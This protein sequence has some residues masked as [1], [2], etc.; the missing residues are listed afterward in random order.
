MLYYIGFSSKVNNDSV[1]YQGVY[2]SDE[3]DSK[4]HFNTGNFIIDWY[5]CMKHLNSLSTNGYLPRC[6]TSSQINHLNEYN[7]NY[8]S[9]YLNIVDD[10]YILSDDDKGIE[11]FVDD[12]IKTWEQL[13]SYA[14]IKL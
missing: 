4:K 8:K 2:L 7:F 10:E 9:K 11:F 3:N 5:D 12:N 13:K 1:V 6:T 14:D